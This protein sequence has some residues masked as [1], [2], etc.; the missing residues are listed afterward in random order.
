MTLDWITYTFAVSLLLGVAAFA[1]E[2]VARTWRWPTRWIW[3]TT[4][5]ACLLLPLLT[6]TLASA[7]RLADPVTADQQSAAKTALPISQAATQWVTRSSA[8]VAFRMEPLLKPAA[9]ALSGTMLLALCFSSLSLALRKRRWRRA[10]VLGANVYL[11]PDAGPAVVGLLRSHIV[12]PDWLAKAA[13]RQQALVIAHES[14]HLQARDPQLL[15]AALLILVL[16]PWNLPLWWQ[17]RRL[18]H[19]IEVDCDTRVLQSGHDL[20][21]YGAALIEI[22]ARHS[23]LFGPIAAMAESRSF[24]EQRIR[25]MLKT[26]GRW[27]RSAGIA[28]ASVALCVTAVAAQLAPPNT[29]KRQAIELP[30]AVL[31][32]Y[33]GVYQM[34]DFVAMTVTRDDKRLMTE[35]TGTGRYDVMAVAKDQFY[36]PRS[37]TQIDFKRDAQGKVIALVRTRLGVEVESPRVDGA[38]LAGKIAAHL[39]REG[40][41]PG[42]EE[43]LRRSA[44]ALTTG[45]FNAE[46]LTPDYARLAE[47]LLP[48]MVKEMSKTPLGKLKSVAYEGVNRRTGEDIYRVEYEHRA[49]NWYLIVNSAGKISY[50]KTR[51]LPQ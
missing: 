35:V 48:L 24:L 36:Q 6:F 14:S 25:I 30:K 3:A 17:L 28:L 26:P 18:R 38:A 46:D 21:E 33:E 8:P 42:G 39:A 32:E 45:K 44:D 51:V 50:A 12:L 5:S 4:M 10:R 40:A 34:D 23:G 15:A 13:P 7:P 16:M 27:S 49:V 20:Q 9:L 22:G 29:V 19:A 37:D 2:R 1:A 43:A 11:A 31:D 47:K 41:M